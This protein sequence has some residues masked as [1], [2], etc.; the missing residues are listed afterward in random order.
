MYGPNEGRRIVMTKNYAYLDSRF[1]AKYAPAGVQRAYFID[2]ITK[3]DYL[4]I[5]S[6]GGAADGHMYVRDTVW[7]TSFPAG[8][9]DPLND[10]N[11][12]KP[13]YN[14]TGA[15][16]LDSMWA[17]ITTIRALLTPGAQ[18][19]YKQNSAWTDY[20]WPLPESFTYTDANLVGKG[21]DGLNIGDLNWF[22]TQKA[23][24]LA[25]KAT[26]VAAI[27]ALAGQV[28]VFKIDT[29]AEAE[30][31]GLGGTAT[32]DKF[33]G[34]SY[35][36]MA[37]GGFIQ[38]DFNL[39]TGGVYGM[40]VWSNLRKQGMRG[41]HFFING[42]EIHDI[43]GWGELEFRAST[44]SA[45]WM[46]GRGVG[47]G[48]PD[49]R[50]QWYFYPKDSILAAEQANFVFKAGKN[51]IKITPSWGYQDF[52]GIDLIAT[53]V[54]PPLGQT[55]TGANLVIALRAP[56]A[57]TSVV[58]PKGEGAPWIPSLFKS[59]KMGTGGTDTLTLT[60]SAAGTYRLRIFGQNYTSSAQM[61]TIKEGATT[62]ATPSLPKVKSDTTGLD[63]VSSGF[64]LSAG[65]HK[66]VLSGANVYIDQVQLIKQTV[67]SAGDVGVPE[68]YALAQN[69]PNPFNPTTTINFTLAKASNVKL[70]VYNVLG[71]KVA[72]LVDTHMYPGAY[73][74]QF[75]AKTL[76]SGVYFYRLEAGGFTADKKMLLVK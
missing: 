43:I 70:T 54:T 53:G 41:E 29:T 1:I 50:W 15:T 68:R 73:S 7:L 19:A 14:L 39:T 58:T 11:W 28:I 62:L 4:D 24:F 59:A 72:T 67:S 10:V 6:V 63:V 31:G 23:T 40:N 46:P 44:N 9:T 27:E 47:I 3:L 38:W 33:T 17:S 57:T 35:F 48:L 30:F 61:I 65:S 75:D 66:F 26:Y 21:T 74:V 49:D 13:Q 32:V 42:N 60:A 25:N 45:D 34:F 69:Y 51:T 37:S 16:M 22:P 5:Y 71:Q 20:T 64:S 52:A 2:P 8:M 76:A 18:F 12:Q 56:D 36:D 55:I